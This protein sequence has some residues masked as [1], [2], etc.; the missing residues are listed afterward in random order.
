MAERVDVGAYG[1]PGSAGW[2]VW[3]RTSW[4]AIFAGLFVALSLM[5][6]LALIGTAVG[7]SVAGGNEAEAGE[8]GIGAGVW[9]W[10][11]ISEVIALFV[12][13][14]VAGRLM[15]TP[16]RMDAGLHGVTIW[17]LKFTLA[18]YLLVAGAGAVLGGA[19]DVMQGVLTGAGSAVDLG[20]GGGS[21][22]T[23]MI[24]GDMQELDVDRQAAQRRI[25]RWADR[26]QDQV[27][28]AAWWLVFIQLFALVA[29]F[30]GGWVGGRV[31]P[32]GPTGAVR[33]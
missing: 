11:L 14:W 9:I 5:I 13:G 28:A 20:A 32:S 7:M 1:T 2:A 16:D 8:A 12:G 24:P 31:H 21:P 10:W 18:V 33:R 6:W 29:A 17:G 30:A 22:A 15:Q 25:T 4:G 23:Q 26:V 3:R 27:T 19:T